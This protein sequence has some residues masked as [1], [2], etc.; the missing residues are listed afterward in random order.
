MVFVMTPCSLV[1]RYKRFEELNTSI[2]RETV[3]PRCW[4]WDYSVVNYR[5]QYASSLELN[6]QSHHDNH[7]ILM[8]L[9]PFVLPWGPS[10]PKKKKISPCPEKSSPVKTET[11]QELGR[12][13]RF[14]RYCQLPDE[15]SSLCFEGYLE[16]FHSNS[17]IL[18][19]YLL[20]DLS[21]NP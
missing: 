20:N 19:V 2:F 12:G 11:I 16:Y 1:D 15:N 13:G 21:R 3:L 6:P 7:V 8:Q 10:P 17:W 14:L 9:V 18:L 4:Y 5:Q